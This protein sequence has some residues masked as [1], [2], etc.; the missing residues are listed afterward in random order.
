MAEANNAPDPEPDGGAAES[1]N[2]RAPEPLRAAD[3]GHRR[4]V[5]VVDDSEDALELFTAWFEAA[6]LVVR[7]A[8]NGKEALELLVEQATPAL[9]VLDVLMPVMNGLE[10]VD[11]ICSYTRLA[12]VPILVV[13]ASDDELPVGTSLIRHLRKPVG[14]GELIEAARE[15]LD[16]AWGG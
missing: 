2:P 9:I 5:V 12:N 10:L 6:G 3:R 14:E 1:E 4:V 13:T 7:S 15:L 16:A 11:V 8:R